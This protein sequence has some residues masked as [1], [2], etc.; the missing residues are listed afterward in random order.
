MEK[1]ASNPVTSVAV[2][3]FSALNMVH[4]SFFC[5]VSRLSLPYCSGGLCPRWDFCSGCPQRFG[6][7]SGWLLVCVFRVGGWIAMDVFVVSF[8]LSFFSLR[9]WGNA[10]HMWFAP[11][12]G[13][14]LSSTL[15]SPSAYKSRSQNLLGSDLFLLVCLFFNG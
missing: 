10:D 9:R 5:M 12:P 1:I 11:L 6:P 14:S 3:V 4:M 2:M 7:L 8:S 15:T 13:R